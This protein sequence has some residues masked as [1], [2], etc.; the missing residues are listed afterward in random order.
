[1]AELD[2][3]DLREAA[4]EDGLAVSERSIVRE[5]VK[6]KAAGFAIGEKV[7]PFLGV[8]LAFLIVLTLILQVVQVYKVQKTILENTQTLDLLRKE[9]EGMKVE[10]MKMEGLT[11]IEKNLDPKVYVDIDMKNAL[12]VDLTYDNFAKPAV[13]AKELSVFEKIANIFK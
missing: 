7:K 11:I 5:K 6:R 1:M 13:A 3:Y 12:K 2:I 8:F 4:L 10:L 9:N